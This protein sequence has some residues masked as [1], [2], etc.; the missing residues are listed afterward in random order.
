MI[1]ITTNKNSKGLLKVNFFDKNILC[2]ETFL[3]I[4]KIVVLPPQSTYKK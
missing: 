2:L 4:L 3:I 1:Y